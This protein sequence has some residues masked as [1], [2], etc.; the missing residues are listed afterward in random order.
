MKNINLLLVVV[1]SLMLSVITVSCEK[2]NNDPNSNPNPDPNLKGE[3]RLVKRDFS[4]IDD[5]I[6]LYKFDTKGRLETYTEQTKKDGIYKVNRIDSLVYGVDNKLEK[7]LYEWRSSGDKGITVFTYKADTIFATTTY[8]YNR[9]G[10][11]AVEVLVL[12]NKGLLVKKVLDSHYYAYTYDNNNNLKKLELFLLDGTL[13][14]DASYEY[15]NLNSMYSNQQ[16]PAWFWVYYG[17]GN[18]CFAGK[19]NAVRLK[20]TSYQGEEDDDDDE[21]DDGN[22]EFDCTYLPDEDNYPKS[23]K[24]KAIVLDSIFTYETIK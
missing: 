15:D 16:V 22:F 19:N 7:L 5:E 9:D 10:Q 12:N 1:L 6:S 4:G 23:I 17:D 13:L 24:I 21:D 8:N 2:I 20:E 14:I 3:K 18:E 11:E